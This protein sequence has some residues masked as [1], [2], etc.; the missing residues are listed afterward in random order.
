L[1]LRG[2]EGALHG[3]DHYE[4]AY[5]VSYPLVA[6]FGGLELGT[7]QNLVYFWAMIKLGTTMIWMIT[8]GLNI[9]MGVAW[10]RFLAF[11]NIWFKRNAR[12]GDAL[13][14]LLPMASGGKQIDFETVFD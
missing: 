1:M 4:P 10:H 8:V 14:A 2:L 12:G 9:S 13:G 11:P 5:V 3:V 6:A 7:L